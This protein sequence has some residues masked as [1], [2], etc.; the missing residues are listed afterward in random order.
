MKANVNKTPIK[1]FNDLSC[2]YKK[3]YKTA[4]SVLRVL[5]CSFGMYQ[6]EDG[7][8]TKNV[9]NVLWGVTTP[10][11]RVSKRY[12]QTMRFDMRRLSLNSLYQRIEESDTNLHTLPKGYKWTEPVFFKWI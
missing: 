2:E 8:W 7:S 4:I 5:S 12:Y 10:K 9:T 11:G 6:R 1:S 3:K